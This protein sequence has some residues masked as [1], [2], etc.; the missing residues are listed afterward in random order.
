M[1]VYGRR[2]S[3][4]APKSISMQGIS[5]K[6]EC[7]YPLKPSNPDKTRHFGVFQ[8]KK[9]V[10]T[11]GLI[12]SQLLT[13]HIPTQYPIAFFQKHHIKR[14]QENAGDSEYFHACVDRK[15]HHHGIDSQLFS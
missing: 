14:S 4:N 2:F 8:K 5:E 13:V 1:R 6:F 3:G 7:I 15:E 10:Y 9:S 12:H 11:P